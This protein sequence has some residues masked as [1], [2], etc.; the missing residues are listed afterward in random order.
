[1]L[2]LFSGA[3]W[4]LDVFIRSHVSSEQVNGLFDSL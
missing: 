2:L 4:G 3:C 1:M